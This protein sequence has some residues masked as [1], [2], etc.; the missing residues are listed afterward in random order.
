LKERRQLTPKCASDANN[1]APAGRG[2]STNWR[3]KVRAG[4]VAGGKTLA[5]VPTGWRSA[6][7]LAIGSMVNVQCPMCS[8]LALSI[9]ELLDETLSDRGVGDDA[10]F[11]ELLAVA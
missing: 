1:S 9:D 7:R 2:P 10:T 6:G 4:L 3:D 8:A 11:D 5:R